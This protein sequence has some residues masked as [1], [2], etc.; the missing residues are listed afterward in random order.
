MT[1]TAKFV[2]PTF[3]PAKAVVMAY[4]PTR[5][6]VSVH[7]VVVVALVIG[8]MERS[9]DP[10]ASGMLVGSIAY[11]YYYYYYYYYRR[12]GTSSYYRRM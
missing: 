9:H 6:K 2:S 8:K 11:Y 3:G 1:S 7:R 4:L 12:N 5:E 10:G